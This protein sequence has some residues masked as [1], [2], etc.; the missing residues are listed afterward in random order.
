MPPEF[1]PGRPWMLAAAICYVA[2][3]GLALR[4]M[5][6]RLP[7]RPLLTYAIVAAG[8][9]LQTVGLHLRGLAVAGCPVGN[10]LELLQFT[11]WSLVLLYFAVGPA[12]RLSILGLFGA[13]LAS[14]LGLGSLLVPEWDTTR[15]ANRL[16]PNAWIEFHAAL[17]VF[18]YGVF[19]LLAL[20]GVMHLLQ[21]ANLKRKRLG[22]TFAQLPS[23]VQLE[24]INVR[25]LV[26]GTALLTIA[27]VVGS[28][29]W[30]SHPETVAAP[31][32]YTTLAVWFAYACVLGL[33]LGRAVHGRRLSWAGILLFA[34]A[35]AT[36][37]PVN[38][39]RPGDADG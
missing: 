30:R 12:F 16:G 13:A 29:F 18:S 8:F 17:A 27:L 28:V 3:F 25:L 7:A 33:R 31:K 14:G 10:K 35:L 22:P 9:L 26:A 39:S 37:V 38:A 21:H 24:G 23:L 5:V 19:G 4:T 6:S 11:S 15:Q 1:L 32:L 36:L 20:T 34:V 2:A